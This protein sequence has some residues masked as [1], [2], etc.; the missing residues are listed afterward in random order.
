MD[1]FYSNTFKSVVGVLERSSVSPAL[2]HKSNNWL[3]SGFESRVY[4]MDNTKHLE[5]VESCIHAHKLVKLSH[6]EYDYER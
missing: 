5:D 6:R 3:I 2:L 4:L 1:T